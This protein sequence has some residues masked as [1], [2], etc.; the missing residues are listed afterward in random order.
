MSKEKENDIAKMTDEQLA[1]Q[2]EDALAIE[3]E[4]EEVSDWFINNLS[5][6]V[7]YL[8]LKEYVLNDRNSGM[9][10]TRNQSF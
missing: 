7:T 1:K 8:K 2:A 10:E 5:M 4:M 6:D 3:G 9:D